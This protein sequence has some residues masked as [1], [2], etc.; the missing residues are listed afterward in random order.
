MHAAELE[1][2][3]PDPGGWGTHV[4][5]ATQVHVTPPPSRP[6]RMSFSL[7]FPGEVYLQHLLVHL[8]VFTSIHVHS[9]KHLLSGAAHG[10]HGHSPGSLPAARA[11]PGRCPF[12]PLDGRLAMWPNKP[13]RISRSVG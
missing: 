12:M 9:E 2:P 1:H 7:Y 5:E 13:L 10:A 6:P 11:S 3:H 4:C 8:G